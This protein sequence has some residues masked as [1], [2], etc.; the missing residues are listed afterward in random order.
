PDAAVAL[1]GQLSA[2]ARPRSGGWAGL[3]RLDLAHVV[4]HHGQTERARAELAAQDTRDE[5]IRVYGLALEAAVTGAGQPAADALAL[6]DRSGLPHHLGTA[7]RA[8]AKVAERI[9]D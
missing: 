3:A 1:A 8:M 2:A 4:A 5:L 7:H 6:A 9:E